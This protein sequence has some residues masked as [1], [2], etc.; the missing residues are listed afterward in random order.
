M[1]TIYF[2]LGPPGCGKTTWANDQIRAREDVAT[3]HLDGIRAAAFGSKRAFWDNP[4]AERRATVRNLYQT[5]FNQLLSFTEHHIILP[6]VNV[7]PWFWENAKALAETYNCVV[8]PVFL[9]TVSLEELLKRNQ[10]R[11]AED[12][13]KP[14]I[15]EEYY[16]NFH[17]PDAWWRSI[18]S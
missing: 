3:V 12:Q 1:R 8:E 7:D 5:I 18:M 15:V 9:G 17:A 2:L 16:N 14:H 6:N 10:V 11:P 13:L 4:N